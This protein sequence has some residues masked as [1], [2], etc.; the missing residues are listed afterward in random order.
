MKSLPHVKKPPESAADW[1]ETLTALTRYLRSPEG[2]PWDQQQTAHSFAVFSRGELEEYIEALESGDWGHSEEEF[3][4]TLFTLLASAA[5]A[6]AEGSFS[7]ESALRRAH[8]KMIRR[9]DHVFGDDKAR[10]PEDAMN[11]WQRIKEEEKRARGE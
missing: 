3:G 5:A 4:D 2:C 1:F 8:E 9:H 11:S 7:L 10:T 6:E